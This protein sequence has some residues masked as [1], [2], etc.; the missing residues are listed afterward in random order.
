MPRFAG[1]IASALALSIV[2]ATLVAGCGSDERVVGGTA[3]VVMA[4][5]PDYLDPQLAYTTEAAEAD[6]IAYTPLLTY[7]HKSGTDGTELIPGLAQR[8]PR[9]SPDGRRYRLTLRPDL[10]YSNGRPV[11]ASDFAYTIERA[12]RL[13]WPG[14]RFLTANIVGAEDFDSGRADGISGISA[15]DATGQITIN[16]VRP[17]G[18]FENVLALPATGLVP[19]GTPMRDL[20]ADPPPG[21]GAYRITNVRPGRRWTM[22]RSDRFDALELPDIPPGSLERIEVKIVHS[23]EAAANQV[24]AGRA[25]GYDPGAPLPPGVQRRARPLGTK[26]FDLVPI[27]STLYFF[28]DTAQPPFNSELARRAVVTALNRPYLEKLAKGALDAGC[29]LIPDGIAGHPSASCPYGDADDRGDLKT[30]RQLVQESG[31]AGAPVVVWVED[32][33]PQRAFARYYTKL[34]NRLGYDARVR[35]APTAQDFGR[36]GQGFAEPQT[37]FGSW[38]NDFPNPSD[39]YS[40]LDARSIGTPGS[41]NEGNVHDLFI[42]QQLEKLNLVQATD[43]G[44]A[45]GEWRDL[46]EYSAQKAY[47]AVLGQQLVP[48]LISARLDPS[49]AVIQPLFLSDWSSWSLQ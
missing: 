25:D 6:W 30:A 48:K 38:F 17:W 47:L 3:R 9:I 44:S 12:I 46:D 24:L 42:Q 36:T 18:A 43:L 35:V 22:V 19:S 7:R 27:P 31:T 5:P 10:V 15:D 40:V 2:C 13:G 20:S 16:L 11:V 33:G 23:P 8:L 1:A 49:S 4:T 29:Y 41:P 32:S 21:V 37:G 28:L 14:K 26:R 34:L 45:A 39:F